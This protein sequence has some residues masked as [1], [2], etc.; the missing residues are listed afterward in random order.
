MKSINIGIANL[1]ISN[2]LKDSYINTNLIEESKKIASNFFDIIK[3][4][5]ILQLEFK[6]YNNM[7]NKHIDNDVAATRYI[8]NS[9]KLF[10]VYT[11]DEIQRERQKLIDIFNIESI[12]F[13][14]ESEQEKIKLYDA[15]SNLISESINDY[16]KIDVDNMHE[17]FIIVLDHLKKPKILIE[18]VKFEDINE[19]VIEIAVDKFND[20]YDSLNDDDKNLIKTLIESNDIEKQ[21]ILESYKSKNLEILEIISEENVKDNITKAIQK[22]KEM[23]Y[24]KDT[25]DDNI[26]SLHELRKELL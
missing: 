23:K 21:A 24:C 8:D 25:V 10:E 14:N 6:V 22:I 20:K 26:I 19:E 16:D 17:S 18:N 7:E 12:Q 13:N 15:I 4:S 9:I 5:P 2:K 11:L 1:I 3:N